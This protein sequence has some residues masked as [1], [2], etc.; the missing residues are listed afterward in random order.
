MGCQA[1]SRHLAQHVPDRRARTADG[2][3]AGAAAGARLDLLRNT[4][5]AMLLDFLA[6]RLDGERAAGE[7]PMTIDLVFPDFYEKHR[8]RL[9][10]GVLVHDSSTAGSRAASGTQP[11][12]ER[13]D[14]VL[15]MKRAVLLQV[16]FAGAPLEP[17]IESGQITVEGDREAFPKLLGLLDTFTPDF[18]IVTP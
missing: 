9:R 8:L 11:P 18:A 12:R 7:R 14:A 15:T 4:P 5:T 2:R 17:Q 6:V 13:P 10:N 3:P 1:E 16:A